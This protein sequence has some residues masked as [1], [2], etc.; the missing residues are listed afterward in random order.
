M[1]VKYLAHHITHFSVIIYEPACAG[2]K[3]VCRRVWQNPLGNF[4]IYPGTSDSPLH[5][6]FPFLCSFYLV[7]L[8]VDT[9]M[10]VEV[11]ISNGPLTLKGNLNIYT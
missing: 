1:E 5:G 3:T 7:I 4:L 6:L 10:I 9:F 8:S 11:E 2:V